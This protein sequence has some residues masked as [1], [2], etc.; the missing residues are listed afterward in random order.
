VPGYT[1]KPEHPV[2]T[3]SSNSGTAAS[4]NN[5]MRREAGAMK[6]FSETHPS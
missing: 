5:E 6:K 3:A 1:K 2:S 4:G